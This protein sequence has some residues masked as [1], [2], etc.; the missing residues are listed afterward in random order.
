MQVSVRSARSGAH[1]SLRRALA[2]SAGAQNGPIRIG[3]L[4]DMSSLYADNGSQG[5]RPSPS[6]RWRGRRMPAREEIVNGLGPRIAPRAI[7]PAEFGRCGMTRSVSA[8]L[9]RT[10]WGRLAVESALPNGKSYQSDPR[11]QR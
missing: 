7:R 4:T 5:K 8:L 11:R 6:G 1:M 2:T 10:I 3:V 9:F